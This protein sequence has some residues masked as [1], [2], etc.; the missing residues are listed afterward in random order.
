MV[1]KLKQL[2]KEYWPY[3]AVVMAVILPW[4]F[5]AGYLFFTDMAWGPS[6]T[7]NWTDGGF[8]TSL[9]VKVFSLVLPVDFLQ[10][11]YL[12]LI[13]LVALMGG[14]KI[15]GLFIEDK[16]AVL[17]VSLFTLFNPFV[18]DRF[19][20]GQANIVLAL[21]LFLLSAGY[22]LEYLGLEQM[23][24]RQGARQSK[25]VILFGLCGGLALQ[26]SV[27]FIF[28][29][30]TIFILF[31]VLYLKKW[32]IGWGSGQWKISLKHISLAVAVFI[33]LNINWLAAMPL[34]KSNTVNF[35]G[36]PDIT[37]QNLAAFKTSG[38]SDVAVLGNVLMM[39]GFWGKD[40]YRYADLT[41]VK[42]NWGRS[43]LLLLPIII[44]GVVLGIRKEETRTLSIGLLIVFVISIIL[45]AGVALS[46][47]A[48]LSYWLFDHF[49]LYKGLRESQKWVSVIVLTYAI[50]L[51]IGTAALLKIKIVSINRRASLLFLGAVIIMQTPFLFWGFSDQVKPTQ[52]PADWREVNNA[53]TCPNGENIL[54]LPWHMYMSFSWIGNVVANPAPDFFKCPVISGTDMEWADI[55]DNSSSQTG[56]S[57][58]AWLGSQ[59]KNDF[60][61]SGLKDNGLGI[62]Y[63]VLTKELDWKNYSWIDALPSLTLFRDTNTLRV[64]EVN[65]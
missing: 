39:S 35:I 19:M 15:A 64:Y 55:Y 23:E 65:Q 42:E 2:A 13:I 24:T 57:V 1:R 28:F 8:M 34:G 32:G 45:A 50:F 9:L 41:T 47:M 31:L 6:I 52:Y 30:G 3:L 49:P 63:V 48:P 33:L 16:L 20:Y 25:S 44:L 11:I 14:K 26:F 53:V 38:S 4:F 51:S 10:K 21:G 36:S 12:G 17:A 56:K 62:K 29:V 59:G 61:K 7:L 18:Y 40:Q 43:F 5:H 58:G 46:F 27:H 22:L 54:F 60:L 37:S